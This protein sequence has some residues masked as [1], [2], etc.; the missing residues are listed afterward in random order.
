[1]AKKSLGQNFLKNRAVLEKIALS[2]DISPKDTII[3]IGPGHGEL[4]SCIRSL[5]PEKI[6]AIEK[7]ASLAVKLPDKFSDVEFILGD[8]L[9]VLPTLKLKEGW[10]L[11][12]NIPYYITG[13]LLRVMAELPI[14]PKVAVLLIQKEVAERAC[15]RPPKMNLLSAMISGWAESSLLFNVER[16][17]FVPVP[18]VDSTVFRL[19]KKEYSPPEKYFK[20]VKAVFKQPRKKAINNLADSLGIDKEDAEKIMTFCELDIDSR[21]QDLSFENIACISRQLI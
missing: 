3:E 17:S 16:K 20:T 2:L 11:A 12:G 10:K 14:P 13:H 5:S 18:K 15:A 8:A 6:I 7:D 21:P 9:S 1:M 4:T 19:D